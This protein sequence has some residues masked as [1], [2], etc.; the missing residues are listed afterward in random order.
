MAPIVE[1]NGQRRAVS[2]DAPMFTPPRGPLGQTFKKSPDT[3]KDSSPVPI[4]R[5][6][7]QYPFELRKAGV[8]GEVIVEFIVDRA[9]A[10]RNPYAVKSTHKGFEAA[11]VASLE[12]WK[13]RPGTK[14]GKRVN[15]RMR[16]PILFT[17]SKAVGPKSVSP[18]QQTPVRVS[19]G[20]QLRPVYPFNA[21]LENSQGVVE[22]SILINAIGEVS[23]VAWRGEPKTEFKGAIEAWLD[24]TEFI[25]AT[26]SGKAVTR[27][28]D[29]KL[30]FSPF[31]GEVRITDEAAAILKRL[32]LGG[33]AAKFSSTKALDQ[34]L[35][36]RDQKSPV[37]PSRVDPDLNKGDAII[38]FFV[39][40][41]GHA[42]L[43]RIITA[44]DPAF[45]YA[46]CQ[47]IAAWR[48]TPPLRNGKP[49]VVKLRVPVEFK[50]E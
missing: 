19:S 16:V 10:V 21:L 33:A 11:A 38:E 26:E 45:G 32:R 3:S 36:P 44:S 27:V 12:K 17:L 29:L 6:R 2:P 40:G 49:V 15:T 30:G 7:P 34:K 35:S 31:L 46:A 22:C 18:L 48:F 14:D 37:F 8:T 47:A 5:V 28:Q 42:Q 20:S 13:F 1:V 25:P 39:D 23:N 43:P 50:R 24:A 9:G 4:K 41:T